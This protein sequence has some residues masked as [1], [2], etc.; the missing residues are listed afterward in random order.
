MI[1]KLISILLPWRLKRLF[2]NKF[3]KY[4]IHPTAKIGLAWVFPDKLMMAAHTSIDHFTVAVHL[5]TIE[6]NENATIGRSNWI[7]GFTTKSNSPHFKHQLNRSAKLIMGK[8]SSVTKNHHIDCTNIITIGNFSTVAGYQSQLL[9]HSIDVME[10]RQHSAPIS[11]GDY[12]FV[13]TNVVILGGAQL[14]AFSVLG[15]K[16]LLNKNF[17]EQ[18][19]LYGGVPAKA[20]GTIDKQAKYFHRQE[21]FVV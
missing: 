2:L 9:T 7:T 13:G 17:T 11:I 20:V 5:D 15:A 12:T 18:F 21:G 8:S 3:F 6:L 16:S 14:P 19:T 1:L 4:Q 10:N